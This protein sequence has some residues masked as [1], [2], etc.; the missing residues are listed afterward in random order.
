MLQLEETRI[1]QLL[2]ETIKVICR[3]ADNCSEIAVKGLLGITLDRKEIFLVQID[4]VIDMALERTGAPFHVNGSNSSSVQQSSS[5]GSFN[6]AAEQLQSRHDVNLTTGSADGRT[7]NNCT[8]PENH[9][10]RQ[11]WYNIPAAASANPSLPQVQGQRG[12]KANAKGSVSLTC[13][14]DVQSPQDCS[15]ATVFAQDITVPRVTTTRTAFACISNRGRGRGQLGRG[16]G[17]CGRG[18]GHN[19]GRGRARGKRSVISNYRNEDLSLS[20]SGGLSGVQHSEDVKMRTR[21]SFIS[22]THRTVISSFEDTLNNYSQYLE[23]LEGG[24]GSQAVGTIQ[25]A[26]HK[27]LKTLKQPAF[28]RKLKPFGVITSKKSKHANCSAESGVAIIQPQVSSSEQ[29]LN[30]CSVCK[31]VFSKLTD[32]ADHYTVEH[33]TS[34]STGHSV[35]PALK[36]AQDKTPEP[37]RC[38]SPSCSRTFPTQRGMLQHCGRVH[39]RRRGKG[40][41]TGAC[42]GTVRKG[43]TF[44]THGNVD[45]KPVVGSV[46]GQIIPSLS[47]AF[48]PGVYA[49]VHAHSLPRTITREE[50]SNA[51]GENGTPLSSSMIVK[52]EIVDAIVYPEH[53]EQLSN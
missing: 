28:K 15:T 16:R 21:S 46:I 13:L 24:N 29:P 2:K 39:S 7:V 37:I 11:T 47:F 30:R 43:S 44:G 1:T 50:F 19:R 25:R 5:H 52:Q 49:N 41:L 27:T 35:S 36:A 32:L 20:V 4:D 14:S 53:L 6:Q 17:Q 10:T 45:V 40:R 34:G 23:N 22:E 8:I 31:R 48:Q 9:T 38:A 26:E 3:S 12:E 33:S 51:E 42:S 18:R